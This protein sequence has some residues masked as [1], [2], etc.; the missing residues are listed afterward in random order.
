MLDSNQK[1]HFYAFFVEDKK[2][3]KIGDNKERTVTN[4]VGISATVSTTTVSGSV[5]VRQLKYR[6][7]RGGKKPDPTHAG[8]NTHT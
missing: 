7:V 8:Y 3:T 5:C 4:T 2:E 6:T 1:R